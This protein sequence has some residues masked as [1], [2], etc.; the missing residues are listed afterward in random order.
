[1]RT[2]ERTLVFLVIVSLLTPQRVLGSACCAGQ[3][4]KSFISLQELQSYEIG[5][6]LSMNRVFGRYNLYG[7]PEEMMH[8]QMFTLS[9]GAGARLS[10]SLEVS[11]IVPF[12]YHEMVFGT[13]TANSVNIG[14]IALGGK[15]VV[16]RSLFR[17][18]WYPTIGI[19]G[20]IKT[21]TGTIERFD[22]GKLVPGTGNGLWEPYLGIALKKEV[23][24]AT[25]TLDAAYTIRIK[26]A[27]DIS[28]EADK[29][30]LTEG[31]TFPLS[32]RLSL[33]AASTQRWVRASSTPDST[34]HSVS[35]A[36]FGTYFFT[37]VWSVTGTFDS[38]IP[39]HGWG[40][41]QQ[42]AQNIS[43]TTKYGF[44]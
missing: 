36:A 30:E 28:G 39:L 13:A 23:G 33:G 40:A 17:D 29:I 31:A 26:R 3:G 32:R 42:L 8:N 37:Q 14:D 2:L 7:E 27:A 12:T 4:P 19:V 6:S 21:P 10:P 9:L 22:A 41:N 15:F 5:L 24:I 35:A 1:M 38:N 34:G 25:L 18:D 16:L 44:F 11:A 20:G 43:F